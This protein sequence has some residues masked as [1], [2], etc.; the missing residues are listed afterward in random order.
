MFG[1]M[2][3]TSIAIWMRQGDVMVRHHYGVLI[4]K[5]WQRERPEEYAQIEDP[6]TFFTR[7][8]ERLAAEIERRKTKL[9]QSIDQTGD[10]LVNLGRLNEIQMSV[11][12]DVLREMGI[13][14]P[15]S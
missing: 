4:Q 3:G 1:R 13:S 5:H 14:T 7:E 10:F 12:S 6:E 15:E 11:E 9:E 2:R 8:G